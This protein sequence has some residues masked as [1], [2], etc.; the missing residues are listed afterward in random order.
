MP[1]V[2]SVAEKADV[3]VLARGDDDRAA[4]PR[5]ELGQGLEEEPA[6]ERGGVL[7]RLG[8]HPGEA[9]GLARGRLDEAIDPPGRG[10][11]D[12]AGLAAGLGSAAVAILLGPGDR[13][14][15]GRCAPERRRRTPGRR[16]TGGAT[17]PSRTATIETP[18][19]SRSA[20]DWIARASRSA[21]SARPV[22]EQLVDAATGQRPG[23]RPFRRGGQRR[24]DV[25]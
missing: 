10:V 23:Q 8:Q 6:A 22:V 21:T 19:P 4:E 18:S 1:A 24:F 17:R 20:S 13:P 16:P 25:G 7:A 12:L 14:G 2:G 5:Q 15:G 9:L 3:Q 11:G